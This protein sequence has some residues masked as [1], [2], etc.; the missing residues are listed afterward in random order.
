[1][2]T[3]EGGGSREIVMNVDEMQAIMR[4]ITTVEISFQNNLAPK[5]KSLSE[6]KYYEGGEASKAMEHYTKMLNKVNEVGDLY[7]RANSEIL[8]MMGQWLEQDKKLK[9]DFVNSLSSNPALVNNL[10]SLGMIRGEE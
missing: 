7:R 2:K 6:T 4:Y 5:L 3:I 10:E 8:N 9:E 1:M